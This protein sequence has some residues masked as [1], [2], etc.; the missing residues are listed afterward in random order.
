MS[1]FPNFQWLSCEIEKKH[2]TVGQ[3]KYYETGTRNL[4]EQLKKLICSSKTPMHFIE[5][6]CSFTFDQPR[7]K[8][9]GDS[10][11]NEK[12]SRVAFSPNRSFEDHFAQFF[13][14]QGFESDMFTRALFACKEA[15]MKAL[16][17]CVIPGHVPGTNGKFTVCGSSKIYLVSDM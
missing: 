15:S 17:V 12:G 4:D 6:C 11:H 7:T 13:H 8:Y 16:N 2:I 1:I 5:F 3:I 9:E 14:H 10:G